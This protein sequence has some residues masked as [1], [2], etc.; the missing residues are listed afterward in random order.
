MR[1]NTLLAS[2]LLFLVP[3][4]SVGS[5]VDVDER[6]EAQMDLVE[7][8]LSSIADKLE[9]EEKFWE[10]LEG[11]ISSEVVAA[12]K[13][14]EAK[15]GDSE[16]DYI[17]DDELEEGLEAALID[18]ARG[19]LDDAKFQV[20]ERE[21]I[22]FRELNRLWNR[23]GQAS[24]ISFL[25][26]TLSLTVEQDAAIS[27]I[28]HD[29][30]YSEW[31]VDVED[32][33]VDGVDPAHGIFELLRVKNVEAILT[34][35]QWKV[36]QKIFSYRIEMELI[37][38]G[39]I[40]LEVIRDIANQ[41][42]ELRVNELIQSFELSEK[43]K[44]MLSVARKGAVSDLVNQWQ[45]LKERLAGNPM[46]FDADLEAIKFGVQSLT[47]Q[48]V[49]Q[50]KWQRT[51]KK[52]LTEAQF[53]E[54]QDRERFRADRLRDQ[55]TYYLLCSS[56]SMYSDVELTLQQHH[57]MAKLLDE[58]I[59]P[60]DSTNL[61][62]FICA[63]MDIDEDKLEPIYDKKQWEKLQPALEEERK[64]IQAMQEANAEDDD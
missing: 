22:E 50:K 47:R 16:L 33:G 23:Y 56:L 8:Q 10:D 42:M 17:F 27:K 51:L 18:Y 43:Q 31:N 32:L 57:A 21:V 20:F 59:G 13:R 6:A 9:L 25:D 37:D 15:L 12:A 28:L 63:F 24:Y 39:N 30:W 3:A 58:E 52:T 1:L 14:I 46:Q 38:D 29:N 41:L 64:M 5:I 36:F 49:A 11:A 7:I 62:S 19:R 40:N 2:C 34:D 48:A 55:L 45:Q 53:A 26:E 4:F 54:V 60:E 35:P 61:V 44:K